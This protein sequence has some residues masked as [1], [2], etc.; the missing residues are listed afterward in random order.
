MPPAAAAE[1]AAAEPVDAARGQAPL[2]EIMAAWFR[3]FV[4]FVRDIL[5]IR[6]PSNRY[7]RI[8][9][10]QRIAEAD[11]DRNAKGDACMSLAYLCADINEFQQSQTYFH[12]AKEHYEVAAAPV[13]DA[14]EPAPADAAEPAPADADALEPEPADAA[15]PADALEPE[16][17][18]EPA[19]APENP[20]VGPHPLTKLGI[21]LSSP[22]FR[23]HDLADAVNQFKMAAGLAED[24]PRLPAIPSA[25]VESRRAAGERTLPT[26]PC[27]YA[28]YW[29]GRAY[30]NGFG[31]ERDTDK[32]FQLIQIAAGRNVMRAMFETA[33]LHLEGCEGDKGKNIRNNGG[34]AEEYFRAVRLSPRDGEREWVWNIGERAWVWDFALSHLLRYDEMLD[35]ESAFGEQIGTMLAWEFAGQAFLFAAVPNI[36]EVNDFLVSLFSTLGIAIG[37]LSIF[38]TISA[39]LK[40]TSRRIYHSSLFTAKVRA[41]NKLVPWQRRRFSRIIRIVVIYFQSLMGLFGELA[42][43]GLSIIFIWAWVTLRSE[44]GTPSSSNPTQIG[45]RYW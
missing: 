31:V 24:P 3:V 32:G 45:G 1:E 40:N 25:A 11:D 17:A 28:Y 23:D 30:L 42:A 29:L 7:N 12:E 35:L 8:R 38:M 41:I 20:Y 36:D 44:Y 34:L 5:L 43:L 2:A 10:E 21:L 19:P 13:P 22:L 14:A 37:C 33:A 26:I 39:L 4:F 15:E 27:P 18:A 6:N 16:P 9:L